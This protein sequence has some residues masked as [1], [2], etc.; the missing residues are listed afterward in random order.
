MD[1]LDVRPASHHGALRPGAGVVHHRPGAHLIVGPCHGGGRRRVPVRGLRH[2]AA[3]GQ[4]AVGAGHVSQAGWIHRGAL[5]A[6]GVEARLIQVG[7][8]HPRG[9][10]FSDA[11]FDPCGARCL[12]SSVKGPVQETNR[13]GLVIRSKFDIKL[14]TLRLGARLFFRERH[15]ARGTQFYD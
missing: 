13:S 7:V 1:V 3:G 15:E 2:L 12:F 9:F 6:A 14:W 10:L 8:V 4:V 11:N 5:Q